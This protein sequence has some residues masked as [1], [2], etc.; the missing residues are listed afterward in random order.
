M[1]DPA[2]VAKRLNLIEA[3]VRELRTIA[4]PEALRRDIREQRF[5]LHTLQ[6][7]A[8]GGARCRLTHRL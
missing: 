4:K 8:L 1:T 7:A 3:Y 5:I 6:L 2:L